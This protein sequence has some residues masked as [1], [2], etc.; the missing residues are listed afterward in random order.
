M[1][2]NQEYTPFKISN[3]PIRAIYRRVYKTNTTGVQLKIATD[4]Q[5]S[6]T[7]FGSNISSGGGINISE[8]FIQE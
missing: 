4:G 8:F 6:I 3:R 2:E 5:V 1:I 7:P